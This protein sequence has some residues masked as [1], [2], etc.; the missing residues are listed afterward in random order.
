MCPSFKRRPAF[1]LVEIL[2]VCAIITVL[3]GILIP[4]VSSVRR[5]TDLLTC[6]NH[7]RQIGIGL[8][9]YIN[10]NKGILPGPLWSG[11]KANYP[12]TG[13]GH[14]LTEFEDYMEIS[15]VDVDGTSLA[16]IMLC[17]AYMD[18]NNSIPPRCYVLRY[19]NMELIDGSSV[20]AFGYP[21]DSSKDREAENP[22]NYMQ[23]AHP[24]R[25]WMMRDLD[26]IGSPGYKGN[27]LAPEQP[28]HGDVR[29][30]LYVDGHVEAISTEND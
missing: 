15:T 18:Q 12:N 6:S 2:V 22:V 13:S 3:A 9:L 23:I 14:L 26:Q 5:Q 24:E 11:Q 29:N 30:T 1:S 21:A 28:V 25:E 19:E 17:P 10:D 27:P 16:E 20:K 4:T 7:L 8:R